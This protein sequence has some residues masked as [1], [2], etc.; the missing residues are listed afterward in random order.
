MIDHEGYCTIVGRAKD[1][2]IRGGENIAPREIE[3]VLFAHPDVSMAS[4]VGVRDTVYGEQVCA[5]VV[6][7]PSAAADESTA[8]ALRAFCKERLSHFKVPKYVRFVDKFPLTVSGKIQ[9]FKLVDES[10]EQLGL[11][12][13]QFG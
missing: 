7:H 3:D 4:V 11:S 9:K 2:I 1:T 6:L 13:I 8:A 10:N 5:C 12:A